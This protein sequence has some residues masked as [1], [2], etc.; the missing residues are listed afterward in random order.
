M[1]ADPELDVLLLAGRF[2]V[3]GASRQ[4]IYLAE[5]LPRS[6]VSARIVCPD[7]SILPPDRRQALAVRELSY[8]ES[9]VL[10][11]LVRWSLA[12]E[13][14]E[15]P[16][17]LIHVQQRRMLPLGRWLARVLQCP[18]VLTIHDYLGPRETLRSEWHWCRRIIAVS[19]SVKEELKARA[20]LPDERITVIRSGVE[21]NV[22]ARAPQVLLPDRAPVV[23]TAG[24]LEAAKGL[25]YFLD[26]VPLVLKR[27]PDVEFLIA[28]AGPEEHNLRRQARELN[29]V[30]HVTFVPNVLDLVSSL[31][32]MDV[33]VLPSLKQGLGTIML[34]AMVRGRPVIATRAGGV[35]S[36]VSDGHTGLLVP[37]RDSAA[38]AQR[39]LELLDDPLRAR[40]IGDAARD[41]VRHNFDVDKMVERT[42]DLYREVAGSPR[43][44]PLVDERR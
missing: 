13:L 7:A 5:H 44:L 36:V 15:R 31:E 40:H 38:L 22:E 8:L 42:A 23:G 19:E 25:R 2:E 27:H 34:E 14:R 6:G 3:R 11:Q 9:P 41:M 30:Q 17:D 29:I 20:Q 24:P 10:G 33:F 26:A 37:P 43:L 28:G 39:V 32:A 1:T 16:P 18:Y 12:R 35:Y 21:T 4:T